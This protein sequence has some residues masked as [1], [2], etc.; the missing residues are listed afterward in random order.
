MADLSLL[1][2]GV[3]VDE[4]AALLVLAHDP[5]EGLDDPAELAH[6]PLVVEPLGEIVQPFIPEGE[7]VLGQK[8]RQ[9]LDVNALDVWMLTF[10]KHKPKVFI[11]QLFQC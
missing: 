1:F 5:K 11:A 7:G 4:L 2:Q 9:M 8:G 6:S 10:P 3:G